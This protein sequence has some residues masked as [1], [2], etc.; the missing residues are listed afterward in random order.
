MTPDEL[1][2]V[3]HEARS[4]FNRIPSLLWRFSDI[5]TNLRTLRRARI[6]W[7]FTPVFRREVFKKHGIDPITPEVGDKFD[8]QL[9]QAMSMVPD[10][11]VEPNTVINVFQRG[12]TLNGSL[13]R[14]AMV[15]VSKAE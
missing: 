9:H 8:P 10:P 6:F 13:V 3:C 2:E 15:V 1:T 4:E 7:Q 11:N 12:Y 5:R 14:P